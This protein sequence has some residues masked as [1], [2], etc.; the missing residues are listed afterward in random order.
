MELKVTITGTEKD[1]NRMFA[2]A[3]L[4]LIMN[5]KDAEEWNNLELAVEDIEEEDLKMLFPSAVLTAYTIKH[6]TKP[7]QS[8]FKTRLDEMAK[9]RGL[10]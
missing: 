8:K 5:E 6:S 10:K 2:M 7:K 9:E 3:G 4:D 1:L